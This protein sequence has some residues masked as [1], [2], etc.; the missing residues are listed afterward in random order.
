MPLCSGVIKVVNIINTNNNKN[1]QIEV[2]VISED[3]FIDDVFLDSVFLF[4]ESK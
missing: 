3:L 2:Q 4:R 1:K